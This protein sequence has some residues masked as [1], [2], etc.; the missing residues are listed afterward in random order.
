MTSPV[1]YFDGVCNLCNHSV[2][3]VLDHEKDT[4]LRFASL[5]SAQAQQVLP[6]LGIDPADLDSLVLVK[7]GVAYARSSGALEITRYLK[8]PWS[9]A[10]V[11]LVIPKSI[12][13]FL[14]KIVAN[15]RYRLF[16]KK[17]ECMIPTPQLKAR[18][19]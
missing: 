18:F 14:Y 8:S 5:Q 1:L 10:T 3:F 17:D 4:T 6:G 19:L 16:G 13:D 2:Q 7:D 11:F 9:W 15:N 12:R